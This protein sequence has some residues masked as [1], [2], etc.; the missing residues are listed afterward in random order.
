MTFKNTGGFDEKMSAS[1][2]LHLMIASFPMT[3]TVACLAGIPWLGHWSDFFQVW[4]LVVIQRFCPL[5]L[6]SGQQ[7]DRTCQF[8]QNW[9]IPF[10]NPKAWPEFVQR[11]CASVSDHV[12]DRV[13]ESKA[14]RIV[15]KF[16]LKRTPCPSFQLL[17]RCL[18][19]AQLFRHFEDF[20]GR[21]VSSA[22][23]A[24]LLLLIE[25]ML[26]N[27]VG[28]CF[29]ILLWLFGSAIFGGNLQICEKSTK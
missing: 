5:C 23:F 15:Y 14:I 11:N 27:I 3:N 1:D 8:G 12:N 29:A 28:I 16:Q 7:T 10:Y 19:A 2:W 21:M 22:R 17:R 18:I 20:H 6:F 26:V 4:L 24:F 13:L 9:T 25:Q